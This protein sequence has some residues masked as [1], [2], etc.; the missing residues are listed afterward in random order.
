M[1][2]KPREKATTGTYHIVIRG[3][4]HRLMFESDRDY[5]KY[6]EILEQYKNECKFKLF[7]YCLMNNHVHLVLQVADVKLE[8]IFRKINTHYSV[9]FNMKYQRVGHLLQ[10]R[11]YS[12][13]IEDMDYLIAAIR[14]VHAN[15]FKAGL[16]AR[17]GLNYPWSSIR[18]YQT[19]YSIITD[20]DLILSMVSKENLLD[21]CIYQEEA[22]CLDVHKTVTRIP[23]DV[24]REII[25]DE[26]NCACVEDFQKLSLADRNKFLPALHKKGLSIRQLNRL[27]GVSRGV[28]E[29]VIRKYRFA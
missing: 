7:A 25:F 3:L 9:W 17:P 14:Y 2:R 26:C 10:G 18:E 21:Y 5:K 28:V 22:D 15:P 24:A 29:R 23:D 19:N 1:A 11:Y 27:T 12:E 13:P 6:I 4:D 20:I 16:E 8:T